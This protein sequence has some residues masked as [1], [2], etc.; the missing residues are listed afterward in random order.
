MMQGGFLSGSSINNNGAGLPQNN[1]ANSNVSGAR[2][3]VVRGAERLEGYDAS[4]DAR[5]PPKDDKGPKLK[6]HP[7]APKRFRT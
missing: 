6:K 3:E 7:G 5:A 1:G 4:G 2:G